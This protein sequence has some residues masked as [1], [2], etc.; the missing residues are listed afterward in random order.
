MLFKSQISATQESWYSCILPNTATTID[1]WLSKCC[2]RW[3]LHN[4]L[5][6]VFEYL[7]MVEISLRGMRHFAKLEPGQ[8]PFVLLSPTTD[9]LSP[10]MEHTNM[11][12]KS[13]RR[14]SNFHFDH[15]IFHSFPTAKKISQEEGWR[16]SKRHT[17]QQAHSL[18]SG[19]LPVCRGMA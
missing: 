8:N 3:L 5:V 15:D 11:S 13:P 4:K 16:S 19:A 9:H 1:I 18:W 14:A 17:K 12:I 6:C 2:P 10:T 7:Q